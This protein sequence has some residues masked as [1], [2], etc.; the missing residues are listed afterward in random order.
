[1]SKQRQIFAENQ[2]QTPTIEIPLRIV[3][4]E[5]GHGEWYAQSICGDVAKVI[6]SGQKFSEVLQQLL[7]APLKSI[8]PS[9]LLIE[10]M[11]C[12]K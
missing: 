12:E 6:S 3:I 4:T 8:I 10:I 2:P 7:N 9:T 1:M 11:R 5:E